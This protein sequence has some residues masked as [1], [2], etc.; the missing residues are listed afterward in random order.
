MAGFPWGFGF[1]GHEPHFVATRNRSFAWNPP[2]WHVERAGLDPL[3]GRFLG[4][5]INVGDHRPRQE[6]TLVGLEVGGRKRIELEPTFRI[7]D[8]TLPPPKPVGGWVLTVVR[9]DFCGE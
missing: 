3:T 8:M 2:F 5:R 4:Y 6:K 1:L 9:G 7:V